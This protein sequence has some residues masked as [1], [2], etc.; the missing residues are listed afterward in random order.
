MIVADNFEVNDKVILKQLKAE[1]VSPLENEDEDKPPKS[2]KGL[3]FL[4]LS[5]GRRHYRSIM[6]NMFIYS[7]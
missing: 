3:D 6:T 1:N 2:R 5:N 7:L 4:N